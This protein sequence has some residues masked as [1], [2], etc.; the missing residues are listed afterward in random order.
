MNNYD[1]FPLVW[2]KYILKYENKNKA[3]A[4]RRLH[5]YATPTH[6]VRTIYSN[7]LESV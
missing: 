5:F 2:E 4:V 6:A 1:Y 3:Y 7:W